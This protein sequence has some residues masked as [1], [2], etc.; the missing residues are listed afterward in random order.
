MT[1]KTAKTVVKRK[2]FILSIFLVIVTAGFIGIGCHEGG[3]G[4]RCNPDLPPNADEC[5]GGALTCQTPSTCVESYC[6]PTPASSS[7]N[8]YCNGQLCPPAPDAGN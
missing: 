2:F 7:T 4:D 1:S 5:G 3:E 8:G 6:C